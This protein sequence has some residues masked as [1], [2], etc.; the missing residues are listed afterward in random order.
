MKLFLSNNDQRS[1]DEAKDLAG[2]SPWAETHV[3]F[4]VTIPN[5]YKRL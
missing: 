5:Y 3:L 2:A 1:E 4:V